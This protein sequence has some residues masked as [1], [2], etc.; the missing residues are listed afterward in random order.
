MRALSALRAL[1]V[2]GGWLADDHDVLLAPCRTPA[3]CSCLALA[4]GSFAVIGTF[5]SDLDPETPPERPACPSSVCTHRRHAEQLSKYTAFILFSHSDTPPPF[6]PTPAPRSVPFLTL[7]DPIRTTKP[8]LPLTPKRTR[9][10]RLALTACP[11]SAAFPPSA[12]PPR[13]PYCLCRTCACISAMVVTPSQVENERLSARPKLG[14]LNHRSSRALAVDAKSDP[15]SQHTI[16]QH[17]S[18]IIA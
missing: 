5:C 10:R 15:G 12:S 11:Y 7:S 2:A 13:L 18:E 3:A 14:R 6:H 17:A 9:E 1:S 16:G 4:T 8:L